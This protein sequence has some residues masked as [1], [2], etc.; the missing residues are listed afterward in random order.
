MTTILLNKIL[1]DSDIE[2]ARS[3]ISE[4]KS[5]PNTLLSL[6]ELL[7]DA[8]ETARENGAEWE[9][10]SKY[11]SEISETEI[12]TTKIAEAYF[13]VI[14]KNDEGEIS[15]SQLKKRYRIAVQ[16]LKRAGHSEEEID[17]VISKES[18]RRKQRYEKS[19]NK[20]C[21]TTETF[22]VVNDTKIENDEQIKTETKTEQQ[23]DK[24]QTNE[25]TMTEIKPQE[26]MPFAGQ[27]KIREDKDIFRKE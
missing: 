25:Q 4:M 6:V 2:K 21:D 8:I 1:S 13:S 23:E 26:T 9:K 27:T 11:L 19:K 22:T 18:E 7:S 24:I 16:L 12:D 17:G 14:K 5:S 10:I 3:E 20:K 15:Y